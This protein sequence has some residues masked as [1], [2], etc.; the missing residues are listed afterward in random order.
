[1]QH[2]GNVPAFMQIAKCAE[3]RSN[4]SRHAETFCWD[5]DTD[6]F[7]P[8]PD[9]AAPHHGPE[10]A[11]VT[12]GLAEVLAIPPLTPIEE[13]L[14]SRAMPVMEIHQLKSG[15]MSY[16]GHVFAV[17]QDITEL[18]RLL[19]RRVPDLRASVLV[20]L[21]QFRQAGSHVP[22]EQRH[23]RARRDVVFRRL[24]WQL[25]YGRCWLD[26]VIVQENLTQEAM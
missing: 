7:R 19:P 8:S 26:I 11:G 25:H 4:K 24:R 17:R 10:T 14:I 23:F 22:L 5:N 12:P 18:A 20:V 9:A 13:M 3:C 1:M 6:P 2:G 15:G 21:K 16:S